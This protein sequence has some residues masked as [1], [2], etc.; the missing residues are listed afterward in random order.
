MKPRKSQKPP[1]PFNRFGSDR[2]KAK[3]D[4]D[5][6]PLPPLEHEQIEG[7]E[8]PRGEVVVRNDYT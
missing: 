6:L 2:K 3:R 7:F 8:V 4:N 5:D 1:S